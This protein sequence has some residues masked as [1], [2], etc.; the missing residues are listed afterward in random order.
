LNSRLPSSSDDGIVVTTRVEGDEMAES[1]RPVTVGEL[2]EQLDE[3]LAEY[4]TRRELK[5]TI[6]AALEPY[7]TREDLTAV[8][9]EL[10][11]HFDSVAEGF[12]DEFK[13]LHDWAKANVNG[14]ERRVDVLE[15]AHGG[16][17]LALETRV[18]ALESSRIRRPE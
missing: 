11:T 16:R 9:D 3:A 6:E 1:D 4:P 8:R 18:T 5:S 7:A 13:N 12:R 15:T 17:L 14:L 10:R 2:R